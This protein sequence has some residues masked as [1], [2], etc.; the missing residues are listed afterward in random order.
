[1]KS[2]KKQ[3]KK[4]NIN[5]KYSRLGEYKFFFDNENNNNSSKEGFSYRTSEKTHSFSRTEDNLEN[6]G[7][8]MGKSD[9][10]QK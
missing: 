3:E 5:E 9:L 8:K 6:Y 2:K 7:K 1:M 10:Q 4:S